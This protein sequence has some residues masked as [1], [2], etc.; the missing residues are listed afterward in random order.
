MEMPNPSSTCLLSGICTAGQIGF[1]LKMKNASK[2]AL[3][4]VHVSALLGHVPGRIKTRSV[5]VCALV[6]G[7][8]SS[9]NDLFSRHV[10]GEFG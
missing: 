5:C 1:D 2:T 4:T 3:G 7:D 8:G 9:V 6:C 10:R